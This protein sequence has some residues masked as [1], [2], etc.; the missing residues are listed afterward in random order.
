MF[1]VVRSAETEVTLQIIIIVII[2]AFVFIRI[3][4][5][6]TFFGSFSSFYNRSTF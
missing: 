4:T 5:V 3:I 1:N 6:A 2:T